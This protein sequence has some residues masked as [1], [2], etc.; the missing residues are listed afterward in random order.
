MDPA[1]KRLA[2]QVENHELGHNSFEGV[3]DPAV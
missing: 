3:T 2:V 1:A